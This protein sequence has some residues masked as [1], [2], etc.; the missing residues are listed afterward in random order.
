M[1]IHNTF[2][3]ITMYKKK[4]SFFENKFFLSHNSH[5]IWTH[6]KNIYNFAAAFDG[7]LAQLA[8][9]LR[10]QRRG[11]QFEPGMLH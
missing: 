5:Q 3:K 11:H 9:A 10:W 4:N 6:S 8:R 1:T 7:V 2:N